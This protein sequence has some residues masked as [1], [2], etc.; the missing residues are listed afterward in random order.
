MRRQT[1]QDRYAG[2]NRELRTEYARIYRRELAFRR[3]L[4]RHYP[5]FL[6]DEIPTGYGNS[7]PTRFVRFWLRERKIFAFRHRGRFRFPTFQFANGVPKPVIGRVIQL[8]RPLDGW[9]VMYWFAAANAWL[10]DGQSPA[11]VLDS[12]SAAVIEAA[13]HA[14][15]LISD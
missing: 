5:T 15:D 8:L 13:S 12:S 14:Y 7:L 1:L 10:P 4:F 3:E 11:S 6:V 2:M 9:V